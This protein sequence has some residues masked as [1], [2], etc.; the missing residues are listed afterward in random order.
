MTDE[1]NEVTLG[2]TGQRKKWNKDENKEV[3]RCYIRSDPSKRG[4]RK[5]M[6]NIW[7][8][9]FNNPIWSEQRLADQIRVIKNNNLLSKT[10]REEIERETI[11][12]NEIIDNN[13]VRINNDEVSSNN[14]DQ[15]IE[16]GNEREREHGSQEQNVNIEIVNEEIEDDELR[17]KVHKIKQWME[18]DEERIRIPTMKTCNHGKLKEKTKEVNEIL[19][20]I[21]TNNITETNRLIYAG[22]RLVVELMDIRIQTQNTNGRH[23]IPP[24][25]K[26]LE[27]Q[28]L[29]MRGD[30]SKIKEMSQGRLKN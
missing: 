26:R 11:T 23:R 22:A 12:P 13:E 27:T 1:E 28:L 5:R 17:E 29:K 16:N 10:E 19:T 2:A 8:D 9:R 4:Y 7:I 3:W 25:K 20:S 6:H 21:P 14:D 15:A 18:E 30:L 24:W